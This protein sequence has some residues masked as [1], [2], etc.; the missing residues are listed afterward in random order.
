VKPIDSDSRDDSFTA[1]AARVIA[2]IPEGSAL[3]YGE[4][5]E[6]AGNPRAARQVVRVL[7]AQSKKRGLPWHRVLGKG[8]IIRLPE[9]SGGA[10]QRALLEAEGWTVDGCRL[11]ENDKEITQ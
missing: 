10:E 7:N 4:V 3:T 9:D 11:R 1:R 2:A 5:A 6:L 8:L